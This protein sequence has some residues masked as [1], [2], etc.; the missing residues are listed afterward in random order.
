YGL[1]RLTGVSYTGGNC[2]N[3]FGCDSITESYG[4]SR[5]G[6]TTSKTLNLARTRL[7]TLTSNQYTATGGLTA[8]WTYDNEGRM[9]AVTYPSWKGDFD[10]ST[11]PGSSYSQGYDAM[12]R[13][14]T[15][16]DAV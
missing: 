2:A 13:L 7:D 6:A 4:Y 11:T 5:P 15:L 3:P 8:N 12:G 14:N 1:G 16:T 9:T 10:S